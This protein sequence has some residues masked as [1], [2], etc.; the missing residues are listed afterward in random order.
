MDINI[1]L[2]DHSVFDKY[3]CSNV[4]KSFEY[5]LKKYAYILR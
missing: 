5:L 2:F 4:L 1:R 3:R